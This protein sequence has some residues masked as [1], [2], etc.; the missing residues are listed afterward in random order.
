AFAPRSMIKDAVKAN[1]AMMKLFKAGAIPEKQAFLMGLAVSV[2]IKCQYCVHANKF[3]AAKA[4]ATVEEIKTAVQISSQV[5]Y[6]SSLFY[7][8][9]M[10]LDKFRKMIGTMKIAKDGTISTSSSKM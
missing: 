4:G 9:E 6:F 10:D 1:K 3:N 8:H 2:A 5:G 7:G